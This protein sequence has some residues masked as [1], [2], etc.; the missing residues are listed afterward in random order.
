M[1]VCKRYSITCRTE[2]LPF[3]YFLC[4]LLAW[5][6]G[7]VVDVFSILFLGLLGSFKNLF[8]MFS[9]L[10]GDISSTSSRFIH[11]YFPINLSH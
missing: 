6:D 4:G 7:S 8:K 11:K 9:H 5:L 2:F 3:W 1:G 10:Q